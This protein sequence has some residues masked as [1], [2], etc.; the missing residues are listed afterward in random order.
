MMAQPL[1]VPL[2]A[3][4]GG[5]GSGGGA[6]STGS[7]TSVDTIRTGDRLTMYDAVGKN[8]KVRFFWVDCDAGVVCW[9]KK[10][11]AR[12]KLGKNTKRMNLCS[13]VGSVNVV[14][15]K[16]R[17]NAFTLGGDTTQL[18]LVAKDAETKHKWVRGC[19]AALQ[20]SQ[21]GSS[22]AVAPT[23]YAAAAA[24]PP[25]AQAAIPEDVLG[26]GV[27]ADSGTGAGAVVVLDVTGAAAAPPAAANDG[28]EPSAT[29][30]TAVIPGRT[31]TPIFGQ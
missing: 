28:V 20:G 13:V 24:A 29:T 18:L 31:A 11:S 12:T 7:P 21:G 16:H 15:E 3:D 14:K 23:S 1:A 4:G 2:V 5:G 19:Q 9:D 26:G 30:A 17:P 10:E 25:V 22:F 27:P 6:A 8:P